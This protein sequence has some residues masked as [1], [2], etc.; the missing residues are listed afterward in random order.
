MA[1]VANPDPKVRTECDE[2]DL[3]SLV[4]C[5]L[6]AFRDQRESLEQEN[7][8]LR[9]QVATLRKDLDT[10]G[11]ARLDDLR[12]RCETIERLHGL[13]KQHEK[14]RTEDKESILRL[15]DDVNCTRKRSRRD[16]VLYHLNLASTR[17]ELGHTK[18]RLAK[19]TS[20][21]P[22]VREFSDI[23]VSTD[24]TA[25]YV[26]T[27]IMHQPV[28]DVRSRGV[29]VCEPAVDSMQQE[30]QGGDYRGREA[31]REMPRVAGDAEG[32]DAGLRLKLAE[33]ELCDLRAK[34]AFYEGSSANLPVALSSSKLPV[35]P[36]IIAE[37]HTVP[38]FIES[39]ARL[40]R[41][42]DRYLRRQRKRAEKLAA[43]PATNHS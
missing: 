34:L 12:R 39:V 10:L 16:Y 35:N 14:R 25:Q 31:T 27:G 4:D 22:A 11:Q 40:E 2:L 24:D 21:I 41:G 37:R 42:A 28:T 1:G 38:G 3:I 7:A 30:P 18:L 29:Q 15:T 9:Y 43:V 32:M 8:C 23:G 5:R 13:V 6:R 36:S 20:R 17:R 19:V 33:A 26:S